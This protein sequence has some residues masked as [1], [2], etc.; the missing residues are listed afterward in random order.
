M[1]PLET[2]RLLFRHH[3]PADLEPFR[4]MES[5]REYEALA[6]PVPKS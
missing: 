4:E 1:T 3:V 2:S 6:P 5:D